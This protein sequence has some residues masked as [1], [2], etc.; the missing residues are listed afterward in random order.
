MYGRTFSTNSRKR[1]KRHHHHPVCYS[2]SEKIHP[3]RKST[4]REN[5]L[6]ETR[7]TYPVPFLI[8]S[9]SM[10]A[11]PRML[12]Q[13]SGSRLQGTVSAYFAPSLKKT[14]SPHDDHEFPILIHH[15]F[16]TLCHHQF[17]TLC[18]HQFSTLCH[19][20]FSTLCHHQFPTLSHD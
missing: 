7:V 2:V 5:P 11:L 15:Y 14:W 3:Q 19:H 10:D 13:L 17:P 1:G 18:H 9:S 6:Q 20:Q 12:F 8:A 16:H 4:P